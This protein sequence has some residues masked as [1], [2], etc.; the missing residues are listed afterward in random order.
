[1]NEQRVVEATVWTMP[2]VSSTLPRPSPATYGSIT[3]GSEICSGAAASAIGVA[4][5]LRAIAH[6]LAGGMSCVSPS[7]VET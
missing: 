2:A 3:A 1:M 5:M 6:V 4:H 7:A